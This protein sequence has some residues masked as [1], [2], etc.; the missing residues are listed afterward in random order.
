MLLN[1]LQEVFQSS[2]CDKDWASSM[3]RCHALPC[4]VHDM[5]H[6]TEP[7]LGREVP[8]VLV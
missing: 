2:K 3:L 7:W 4:F 5:S 8:G 6:R 1:A